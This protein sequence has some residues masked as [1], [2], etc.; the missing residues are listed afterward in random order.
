MN[1]PNGKTWGV[2]KR[3]EEDISSIGATVAKAIDIFCNIDLLLNNIKKRMM[4]QHF[5]S[6]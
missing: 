3:N 2:T 5:S 4:L 6:R 1:T